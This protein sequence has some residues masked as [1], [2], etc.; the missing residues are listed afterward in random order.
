VRILVV[1]PRFPSP[2]LRGDQVRALNL[3]R[4]L[5]RRGHVITLAAF[6]DP[7]PAPEDVNEL[8]RHC[9]RVVVVPHGRAGRGAGLL[10]ALLRGDPLQVGLHRA[11]AMRRVVGRL[12]D[13]A[14]A[15]VAIVQ[16]ARMA[17]YLAGP[18]HPPT[19]LDMVDALSLN[20]ARRAARERGPLGPVAAWEARRLRRFEGWAQRV[21][22]RTVA[23]SRSDAEALAIT[24]GGVVP[25]GVDLDHFAYRPPVGRPASVVCVG[26]MGYFPNVQG[27][28][29]FGREVLPR[30]RELV[31]GV[32]VEI[33]GARPAEPVE[34]LGRQPDVTVTGRVPDVVPH[35]HRAA[36]AIAPLQAGTGLQ[37]KVLEAMAAGT[38][39]VA[40]PH[41]VAG[42]EAAPG[43]DLMVAGDAPAFA[44]AVAGLIADPA[45]AVAMA[46]AARGR[47]EE[48]YSW[49]AAA[50][51]LEAEL[52]RARAAR[53]G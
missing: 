36:V 42:V 3:I 22:D 28:S 40:T 6:A 7:A 35:L 37:N 23:V 14:G 50:A 19:V 39:V 53:R 13:P 32:R 12:A 47:V 45:A 18:G 27:V 10:H 43:R 5:A 33:V 46:A 29:W 2:P 1:T 17:P 44:R 31:P 20:M 9:A 49:D 24:A 15:D 48:R 25:N 21:H 11:A 51:A 16:L 26:N 41:A 38:P 52:E 30:L 34:R 4:A 8:G